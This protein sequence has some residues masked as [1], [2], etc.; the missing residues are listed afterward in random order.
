MYACAL[1]FL[2]LKKGCI[3]MYDRSYFERL[4]QKLRKELTEYSLP[5]WA[6]HGP[7][8]KYGGIH[9][10][11]DR[12]G[13]LTSHDKGGWQQGRTAWTFSR[14][15]HQYGTNQEYLDLAKSCLD[16]LDEHFIDPQENRMYFSVAG[17]GT[18]VRLR[19]RYYAGTEQFYLLGNAEYYRATGDTKALENA[20]R[21]LK[22][23]EEVGRGEYP[24]EIAPQPKYYPSRQTRSSPM[25]DVY[26]YHIMQQID[27][28]N[29]ERYLEIPRIKAYEVIDDFYR[30]D[31]GC[32]LEVI[33]PNGEFYEDWAVGREINPGHNLECV[34]FLCTAAH[35]LDDKKILLGA[36]KIYRGAVERGWDQEYGGILMFVDA[37]GRP[38]EKYEH[39]M[40]FWWVIDEAMGAAMTLF[41]M[42][43]KEDYLRDFERFSDYY[44]TFFADHEYG[45]CYGYLRRDGKPTEPIAKG[46]LY[47]GAFHTPRI[48]MYLDNL[49]EQYIKTLPA[50]GAR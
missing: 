8:P 49:L 11:L 43:G 29:R 5:F 25:F 30:E 20:R 31:L 39:D 10:C 27:P 1:A 47:K 44:F 19:R 41:A 4:Q 37:L 14:Y 46:N 24:S 23:K 12:K 7:D 18:P 6:E 48:M 35:L 17:D 22:W 26:N 21:V 16:F 42:T 36:E 2:F 28:E 3:F 50:E 45:D 33:G 9:T 38:P 34:W 15:C 13:Q 40:K 32:M